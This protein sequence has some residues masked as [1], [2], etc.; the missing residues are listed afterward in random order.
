[1]TP[2]I[3]VDKRILKFWNSPV[4]SVTRSLHKQRTIWEHVEFLNKTDEHSITSI[5]SLNYIPWSSE[6]SFHNNTRVVVTATTH[7]SPKQLIH[8]EGIYNSNWRIDA[9]VTHLIRNY[10]FLII[11][12]HSTL[13][14]TCM[15]SQHRTKKPNDH[16]SRQE[17]H[18]FINTQIVPLDGERFKS[19]SYLIFM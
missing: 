18:Y 19:C 5:G 2:T 7:H 4:S 13:R 11:C 9:I 16:R 15:F 8:S 14:F 10:D 17:K 6:I 3:L 12:I 1:M